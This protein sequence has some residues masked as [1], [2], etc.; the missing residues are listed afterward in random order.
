MQI[1]KLEVNILITFG[2]R[3]M[4]SKNIKSQ[5]TQEGTHRR[6]FLDKVMGNMDKVFVLMETFLKFSAFLIF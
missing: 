5:G 6:E 2:I 3:A 4:F 1:Y